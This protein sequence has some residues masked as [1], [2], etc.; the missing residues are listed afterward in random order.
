MICRIIIL[1]VTYTERC[2]FLSNDFVIYSI[3]VRN[4]EEDASVL[5][6]NHSIK[7]MGREPILAAA[8]LLCDVL[9][10]HAMHTPCTY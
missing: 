1:L 4:I 8:F 2:F 6:A 7:L 10:T 3:K 9:H 5:H